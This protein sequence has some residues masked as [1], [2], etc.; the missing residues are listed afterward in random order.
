M[1]AVTML[2]Q[3]FFRN[4]LLIHSSAV[5]SEWEL[6][7]LWLRLASSST[8]VFRAMLMKQSMLS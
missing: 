4:I 1:A 2:L 8:V 7:W 6:R 3:V 5:A